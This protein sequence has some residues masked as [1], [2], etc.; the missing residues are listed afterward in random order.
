MQGKNFKLPLQVELPAVGR[1]TAVLLEL[2][3]VAVPL[4]G[5]KKEPNR[6]TALVN[7]VL[8]HV[9]V[10]LHAQKQALD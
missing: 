8:I 1:Q 7:W 9:E 2:G 6:A 3:S 5:L 4:A 10:L